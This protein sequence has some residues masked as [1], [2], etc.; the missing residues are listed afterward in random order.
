MAI[1]GY[2]TTQAPSRASFS[3]STYFFALTEW[4]GVD[5]MAAPIGGFA[6]FVPTF[7]VIVALW[8]FYV[9][10]P[11]RSVRLIDAI[12]GAIFAG[13]LFALLRKV[14][15]Y[16]VA[17]FPTYQTIYGA[18]SAIPIFL[19]WMYLSWTVVLFGAEMT[20][21]LG[22]WRT[23]GGRPDDQVLRSGRRL[24]ASLRVLHLL[25]RATHGGGGVTRSSLLEGSTLGEK[26]LDRVVDRLREAGYAERTEDK[27]WMAARDLAE[28]SLYDLLRDLEL[29]LRFPKDS[30]AGD[31]AVER[32]ESR[33]IDIT[34]SNADNQRV[35]MA[36]SLKDLLADDA[37][38]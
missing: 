16:Y 14:F 20:A 34:E 31:R 29:D 2:S 17:N 28:V 7:M 26:T 8:L 32:W 25:A 35:L 6:Q 18:V 21:A 22:E 37:D 30:A 12:V 15:G 13:L 11:N 24:T 5:R 19:I 27:K 38:V 10:I 33:L 36:I 1:V 9:I 23:A 4:T 3:L